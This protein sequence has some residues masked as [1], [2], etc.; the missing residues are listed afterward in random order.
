MPAWV[1]PVR[2]EF[3]WAVCRE[4]QAKPQAVST[5]LGT[6]NRLRLCSNLK[7]RSIHKM[8]LEQYQEWRKNT[9]PCHQVATG[10]LFQSELPIKVARTKSSWPS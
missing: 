4:P 1:G 3:I 9:A 5:P 10:R 8:I 6:S 7:G 2:V